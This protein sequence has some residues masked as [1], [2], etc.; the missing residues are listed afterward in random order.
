M[1][2]HLKFLM[3]HKKFRNCFMDDN[4]CVK[5]GDFGLSRESADLNFEN[6]LSTAQLAEDVNVNYDN[7]VGV[8]TMNYAS[9]EQINGSDYDSSSDVYSLGIIL[10]ELCH[11]MY[12]GME[13]FKSFEGIRR[14][15]F[16]EEWHNTVAKEFPDVHSL[17]V[18]MISSN[19]S[20][21]P[22][23][24]QIVSQIDA[25]VNEHTVSSLDTSSRSEDSIF[26]RVEATCS[27]GVLARTMTVI[28]ET[29]LV[30]ILQYSLRVNESKAI[31]EFALKMIDSSSWDRSLGVVFEKLRDNDEITV[32]RRIFSNA[33]PSIEEPSQKQR[34]LS[35]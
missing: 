2:F 34:T 18:A 15:Q 9:P 16:P 28:N 5:I 7:T 17:I 8:G 19:P 11:P 14:A 13:R 33:N 25:L 6:D 23:A 3:S 10:F 21:R 29:G 26:I 30:C 22:T 4:N 35:N 20:H 27:E 31:M 1:I 32:I 12:T 24:A